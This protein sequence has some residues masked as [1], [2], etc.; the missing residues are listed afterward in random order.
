MKFLRTVLEEV[1]KLEKYGAHICTTARN[2]LELFYVL[3]PSLHEKRA[4]EFPY[5]TGKK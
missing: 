1:D 4:T 2:M 5:L 3:Y